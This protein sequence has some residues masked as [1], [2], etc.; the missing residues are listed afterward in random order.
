MSS[1]LFELEDLRVAFRTGGP[2]VQAVRGVSLTVHAGETVGIVG[3][4]GSGKSVTFLAALG[5]LPANGEVSGEVRLGGRSLLG[6]GATER[7]SLLGEAMAIV[8]QN[9]VTAMDPVMSIGDQ[10]GEAIRTHTP[11]L[12]RAEV[13]AR[14]IELLDRVGITE[15]ERRADQYPHEFSGGMTQRVMIATAIAN[16]PKLLVADEPTT[17]VDVTIQAQLLALLRE[18]SEGLQ[19]ASILITH[20]L[21]VVAENTQRVVVMYGGLVMEEGP[22]AEVLA[23][24]L[25]PYTQGLLRCHPDLDTEGA[26]APIP[27]NPPDPADLGEGCPFAERCPIGRTDPQC[28]AEMPPL[29]TDGERRVACYHAGEIAFSAAAHEAVAPATPGPENQAALMVGEK[30]RVEFRR[31]GFGFTKRGG[32]LVAVDDVD[33]VLREGETLG[34]V[35]ESGSGKSTLAHTMIRLLDSESGTVF[36]EGKDITRSGRRSLRAMRDQVQI[37]FQD[38]FTSLNPALSVAANAAEPLRVRGVPRK[39][40]RE[41]VAQLF[42]EVGLNLS[43]I[44]RLPGELSGGQLQRVGIARALSVDPSVLVLDEP[45]SALDV[46]IQAQIL[47]L[48]IRLQDSR[49]LAYMFI[50]H[51]MAVVR[52]I[53]DRVAVMYLGRI[54]EIGPAR[55][56]IA[57]PTHPYTEG[58][59]AAVPTIQGTNRLARAGLT[60]E[61][62][63]AE[64]PV[65]GCRFEPRCRLRIQA[66]R[67]VDPAL[68]EVSP[69]H[70][71]ACIVRAHSAQEE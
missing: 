60:T 48:L 56:L 30:V 29:V 23:S 19:G 59:I 9:P 16:K 5:L 68:V 1:T 50:S 10:I 42:D 26:L 65:G 15:P 69:G 22:T 64:V 46:S 6:L 45:V 24:P 71:V 70:A 11:H 57:M 39:E 14:V 49:N 25:H 13:R 40:R 51:D 8:F 58:M 67:E 34:V 47:N 36:F 27:G 2:K 43:L 31:R 44:D 54:V 35:G 4:S 41:R 21:G 12:K 38:P 61:Q 62:S 3:E 37:V 53:A 32:S 52:Y 55:E 7:R 20:D 17:A 66:C 33:L 63:R 18:V 28:H